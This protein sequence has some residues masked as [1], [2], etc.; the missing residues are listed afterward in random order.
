MKTQSM[1]LVVVGALL[2]SVLGASPPVA[3]R[4]GTSTRPVVRDFVFA[5]LVRQMLV[6]PDEEKVSGPQRLPVPAGAFWPVEH[7]LEWIAKTIAP[8]WLPE[9][10]LRSQIVLIRREYGPLSAS[11]VR[12]E[13]N[14]Y[15]I[16]V[17][18]TRGIIVIKL[19]PM[20]SGIARAE[21]LPDY[22]WQMCERVIR[23]SYEREDLMGGKKR[24]SDIHGF[25]RE[26][27]FSCGWVGAVQG[28]M[29][30]APWSDFSKELGLLEKDPVRPYNLMWYTRVGWYT[31]GRMVAFWAPK[32]EGD[33][34]MPSPNCS[35]DP[36]G[37]NWFK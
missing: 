25:I 4:A 20:D 24:V 30:G 10:D 9:D 17:T 12:W 6:W 13:K 1:A 14:G 16:E 15:R 29:A 21:S 37:G 34:W 22:A 31:D 32:T 7:T 8:N 26:Y 23:D 11:H 33:S 18:Q 2:Q 3:T 5:P 35:G 36:V 28:G 19:T 27:S